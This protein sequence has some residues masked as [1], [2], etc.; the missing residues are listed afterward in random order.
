MSMFL[1]QLSLQTTNSRCQS[2]ELPSPPTWKAGG[3]PRS[4]LSAIKRLMMAKISQ[5]QA[6][7]KSVDTEARGQSRCP[8]DCPPSRHRNSHPMR[9]CQPPSRQCPHQMF[10]RPRYQPP[11]RQP[12]SSPSP[13][14]IQLRSL[15]SP[16]QVRR[17][18]VA[19][20]AQELTF[21]LRP[22]ISK[23]TPDKESPILRRLRAVREM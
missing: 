6:R 1:T 5:A 7:H 2:L 21:P 11:A 23:V 9:L 17:L 13:E 15:L 19:G 8:D 16:H 22:Q 20:G 14:R 12:I 10:P 18:R 4:P 3:A